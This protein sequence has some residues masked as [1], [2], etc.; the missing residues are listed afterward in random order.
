MGVWEISRRVDAPAGIIW[1][2]LD[3]KPQGWSRLEQAGAGWSR[4]GGS[5]QDLTSPHC[6]YALGHWDPHELFCE[7]AAEPLHQICQGHRVSGVGTGAS[8][9]FRGQEVSCIGDAR[10]RTGRGPSVGIQPPLF[11][12]LHH[13]SGWR[14]RPRLH[15]DT[16]SI[17]HAQGLFC[18]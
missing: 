11:L 3:K 18:H 8:E 13:C 9:S 14:L 12:G 5:P 15:P 10:H 17:L 6:I 16:T 7:D 4:L 1:F 2:K